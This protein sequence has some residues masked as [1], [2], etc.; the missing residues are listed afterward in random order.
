MSSKRD[1]KYGN[2]YRPKGRAIPANHIDAK[3]LDYARLVALLV[4]AVKEQQAQIE[5]L[6]AE[7]P[8]I[9]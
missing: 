2:G 1:R 7:V 3:S 5:A 6:Q 8:G 4:E 9:H